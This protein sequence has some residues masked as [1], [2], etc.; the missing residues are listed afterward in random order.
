MK[1][2]GQAAHSTV[3]LCNSTGTSTV[4]NPR[5]IQLRT[6]ETPKP[7]VTDAMADFNGENAYGTWTLRLERQFAAGIY[8]VSLNRFEVR[9]YMTGTGQ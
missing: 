9:L 8:T 1:A 7:P 4:P 3:T 2:D 5:I 6:G